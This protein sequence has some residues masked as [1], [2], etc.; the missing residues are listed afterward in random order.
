MENSKERGIED[1]Y[2]LYNN[3][4]YCEVIYMSS[5]VVHFHISH[6]GAALQ[7]KEEVGMVSQMSDRR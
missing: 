3:V 4:F 6:D 5:L 1:L 7:D 2:F